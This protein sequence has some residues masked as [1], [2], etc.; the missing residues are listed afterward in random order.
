MPGNLVISAKG[1]P[2]ERKQV[3]GPT[4]KELKDRNDA[5]AARRRAKIEAAPLTAEELA[6]ILIDKGLIAAGEVAAAKAGR[7]G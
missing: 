6:Q 4:Q 7:S 3:A 2:P 5:K 1:A